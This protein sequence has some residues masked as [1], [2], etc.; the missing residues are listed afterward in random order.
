MTTVTLPRT[1]ARPTQ[2]RGAARPQL[3]ETA[4][5]LARE[6]ALVA[7]SASQQPTRRDPWLDTYEFNLR[8]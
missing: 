6:T 2:P 7:G 3:R 8:W 4:R 1:A 5:R